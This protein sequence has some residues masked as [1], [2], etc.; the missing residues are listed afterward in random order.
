MIIRF[1][2]EISCDNSE[3]NRFIYQ[4]RGEIWDFEKE[5]EGDEP[6]LKICEI[7]VLYVDRARIIDERKSLFAAMDSV[8]SETMECYEALI[9][10][11]SGRWKCEVEALV[12]EDALVRDNL[13]LISFLRI[14]ERFRGK[15]LGAK[16]VDQV[17]RTFGSSCGVIACAPL[18]PQYI[19]YD[20][21]QRAS[22][23]KTPGYEGKRI[24][25]FEK[26]AAF[27]KGVG[28]RNLLSSDVYVLAPE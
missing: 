8:S 11:G 23:R 27:W 10:Q 4:Y 15:G 28:F 1:G 2:L 3:P 16:V 21:P 17:I 9:D 25:A 18:P 5:A 24:T 13:L 14:E 22:E 26:V 6:T 7:E 19:G 20:P 12:G